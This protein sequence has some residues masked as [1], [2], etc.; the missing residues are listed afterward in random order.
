V[1]EFT[2]NSKN[3]MHFWKKL[4]VAMFLVGN[5]AEDISMYRQRHPAYNLRGLV[6]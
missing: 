2:Y 6:E 4:E 1:Y 5:F 3:K